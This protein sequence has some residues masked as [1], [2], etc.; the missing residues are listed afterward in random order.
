MDASSDI[1]FPT[2][3][4]VDSDTVA[5]S[6]LWLQGRSLLTQPDVDP[7]QNTPFGDLFITPA[8]Y[9]LSIREIV[10]S[11]ILKDFDLNEIANGNSWNCD[12]V[13]M[14]LT[15]LGVGEGRAT[16]SYGLM[17]LTFSH[18]TSYD[19]NLDLT[20]NFNGQPFRIAIGE[21]GKG[22]YLY[23]KPSGYRA[24]RESVFRLTQT[25]TN[26][27]SVLVPVVGAS[28]A[29]VESGEIG[30]TDYDEVNLTEVRAIGDFHTGSAPST[31][32]DRASMVPQVFAAA[33]PS[34]PSGLNSW[35]KT[36]YPQSSGVS[37]VVSGDPE[38]T[39][40]KTNI[41]G[42]RDGRVDLYVRGSSLATTT[43][44]SRLTLD[45]DGR[46]VG[47]IPKDTIPLQIA[48]VRRLD[49]TIS[50]PF[51]VYGRSND[52]DTGDF[53]NISYSDKE[54]LG[55]SVTDT[56]PI[57]DQEFGA[58]FTYASADGLVASASANYTGYWFANPLSR[59]VTITFTHSSVI[60][61]ASYA[62]ALVV[63]SLNGDK[64][65]VTFDGNGNLIPNEDSIRFFRGMNLRVNDSGNNSLDTSS[66]NLSGK[67]VTAHYGGA[68]AL[69]E[70]EL[71]IDPLLTQVY[72]KLLDRDNLPPV[73][74][75]LVRG[76]LSCEVNTINV[77][78][79]KKA[80]NSFNTAKATEEILNYLH[81]ATHP[82]S[83]ETSAISEIML[84]W[85]AAGVR[86][87]ELD[88]LPQPT[89]ADFYRQGTTWV[90][91]DKIPTSMA[92]PEDIPGMGIRNVGYLSGASNINLIPV[93]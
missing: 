31:L 36:H 74:D 57:E 60:G 67:Q 28:G 61:G 81:N 63:D 92:I 86:S 22:G 72:S 56:I 35:V 85:G 44:V 66:R 17:R 39:R 13:T 20:F 12:F 65:T 54:E 32:A 19:I 76:F 1:Y 59:M 14:Y 11:R 16:D 89:Q 8:A 79:R 69:F 34:T 93:A 43:V 29:V 7:R 45:T 38:M 25:D 33:S 49:S 46:W 40:D 4:T 24:S 47:G 91:V 3:S 77:F 83:F 84:Y 15:A 50:L 5:E 62:S 6:R 2:G 73:T 68:T 18:D 51:D 27:Y 58:A 41:L 70:V 90:A 42:M 10:T 52:A 75:I 21:A 37:V 30:T 9:L 26:R 82:D 80:G 88:I 78:Y 53:Y 87:I 55:L 64:G 48:H 71:V 23:V